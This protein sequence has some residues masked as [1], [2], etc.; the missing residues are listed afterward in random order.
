V[1]FL[2]LVV[3]IAGSASIVAQ[4]T[5]P[6]IHRTFDTVADIE[7]WKPFRDADKVTF[8]KRADN[9]NDVHSGDGSMVF[10]Y[11]ASKGS[12]P[13]LFFEVGDVTEMKA[14]DVW[15]K[16]DASTAIIVALGERDEQVDGK[17]QKGESYNTIVTTKGHEWTHATIPL[18]DFQ[19]DTNDGNPRRNGKLDTNKIGSFAMV[20]ILSVFVAG[21]ENLTYIFG[22]HSGTQRI[23]IDD[24]QL[25]PAFV[26]KRAV[27]A[28]NRTPIDMFNR[29]Y[30]SWV[31]SKGV[32][33]KQSIMPGTASGFGLHLDYERAAGKFNAM[34][35]PI[36]IGAFA[37]AKSMDF[38]VS[39]SQEIQLIVGIEETDG[40]KW[41]M[42]LSIPGGNA[43]SKQA[44]VFAEMK[45]ADDTKDSDGKLSPEKIKLITFADATPD[46]GKASLTFGEI[47]A[48]KSH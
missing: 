38:Q 24:F 30:I 9:A 1:R 43:A 29:N 10:T 19:L 41:N 44:V 35:R 34:F 20:D 7:G 36:E 46:A 15:F 12:L 8:V 45:P 31:P 27:L 6:V 18:E 42:I 2:S 48:N 23:C 5:K 3:L 26:A 33:L 47:V 16:T 28:A 39:S 25:A 17:S 11:V 13:V 22:D 4:T 37:N 14:V 32:D 40:G 21:D